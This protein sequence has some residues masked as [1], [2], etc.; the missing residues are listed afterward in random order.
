[1]KKLIVCTLT[2]GALAVGSSVAPAS[3]ETVAVAKAGCVSKT[4]F[5]KVKKGM[6]KAKVHKIFGTAGKR[7]A[8]SHGGGFTFEIRS[9]KSCT[10]YGAV[11][12]GFTNGKLDSKVAVW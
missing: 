8:I 2:L 12:V 7:D 3:A 1:M 10:T 11:S 5:K 4:E 9:Y 6:G